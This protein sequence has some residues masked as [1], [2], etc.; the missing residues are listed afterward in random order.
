MIHL[1]LLP[2]SGVDIEYFNMNDEKESSKKLKSEFNFLLSSRL[3]L[4]KGIHEYV[5]AEG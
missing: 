3:L 5:K 1:H 4:S 2:G